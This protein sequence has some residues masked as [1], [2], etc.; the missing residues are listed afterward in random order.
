MTELIQKGF[1]PDGGREQLKNLP[2]IEGV[3]EKTVHSLAARS[4]AG[5]FKRRGAIN[6]ERKD[7]GLPEI[8]DIKLD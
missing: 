8:K 7:L 6:L 2:G 1:D 3:D 5:A 4:V